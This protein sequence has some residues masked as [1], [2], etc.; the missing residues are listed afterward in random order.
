MAHVVVNHGELIV[1]WS[2]KKGLFISNGSWRLN[3]M[4]DYHLMVHWWWIEDRFMGISWFSWLNIII[5]TLKQCHYWNRCNKYDH[6]C[7]RHYFH[8][9][10]S[11]PVLSMIVSVLTLQK[12]TTS[13]KN[14]HCPVLRPWTLKKC[15][16]LPWKT[17][18][19]WTIAMVNSPKNWPWTA[20]NPQS[21]PWLTAQG[22]LPNCCLAA[23]LTGAE[24][25]GSHEEVHIVLARTIHRR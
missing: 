6:H 13:E 19:K 18:L 15:W 14:D 17:H 23:H 16:S 4:N 12:L 8:R 20:M 7:Y 10:W 1:D 2:W 24:G 3:K 22:P 21:S 25:F 11:S 5:A 9:S